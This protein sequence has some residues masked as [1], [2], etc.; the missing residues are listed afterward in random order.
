MRLAYVRAA[1]LSLLAGGFL[2]LGVLAGWPGA[3]RAGTVKAG[4]LAEHERLRQR[5]RKGFRQG[6]HHRQY[7]PERLRQYQREHRHH[8]RGAAGDEHADTAT[9]PTPTPTT[10]PTKTPSPSPSPVLIVHLRLADRPGVGQHPSKTPNS[11]SPSSASASAGSGSPSSPSPSSSSSSA[12]S[13]SPTGSPSQTGSASPSSSPQSSPAATVSATLDAFIAASPSSSPSASASASSSPTS[14]AAQPELCVSVQRSKASIS[15]GQQAAYVVQ[16]STKNNGSASD[17]TV[18]LTA[19][20]S[21]QQATFTGRLRQGR[22]HRHLHGQLRVGQ[23]ASLAQG[24]DPGRGRRHP[25]SP[26]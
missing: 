19:S 13:T 1:V 2:T 6:E 12:A 4:G 14:T 23:A 8:V 11:P 15:R 10:H 18:A 22:G 26:R 17:V 21:S 24:A 7:Q 20:P 5:E 25:W 3:A 16:V 9:Q